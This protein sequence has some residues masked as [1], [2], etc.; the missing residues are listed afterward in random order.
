MSTV[1]VANRGEIAVRIVAACR[2]LGLS[3][4]VAVSAADRDSLA[5]RLADRALCIGP[6]ASSASY[7]RAELLVAAAQAGGATVLHPGY[8]FCSEQPALAEACEE[9]GIAFAGPRPA[10][11]RELGD[12]TSARAAAERVGVPVA[13]GGE[14]TE[15]DEAIEAAHRVG[16]PVLVKA[17]HGGGGRGIHL[18]EDDDTL[19]RV[20]PRAAAEARA[21]FGDPAL[22][23]ERFYPHARHVEVQVFGDGEGGV[24]VLGERDCSV[25]RRHQKLVEECPAPGL[26][27]ATREL[28]HSSAAGLVE[29]TRY[30]GA[31]TVEFLVDTESTEDPATVVFLEVNARIQVEH[32]ITEEAFG[33]DLVAAQLRLALGLPH[34]LPQLP[35]TPPVHV[36]ECRLNAEDPHDGFRPSPGRITTAEF[37][38]GPGVRIDTHVY[39]GYSFPPHY[40]SLLAKMIV[41]AHDRTAAVETML[42]ALRATHITGVATTADLHEHVLT[43][44]AFRAGGVTTSWLETVWPPSTS[45]EHPAPTQRGH[46]A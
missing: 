38:R 1:L 4:V 19:R 12:K 41:R 42:G 31:G 13:P 35:P 8:G 5:A 22:Y 14:F 6:A 17:V 23:L 9:A 30:R 26:S 7:L 29:S 44:A 16:Y 43:Q 32:P 33:V 25:Q 34:G 20:V 40:D 15:V 18:V 24:V 46:A 28:L 10:T 3:P 37:P 11:L 21:G 2:R 36:I 45:P 27:A 39:G